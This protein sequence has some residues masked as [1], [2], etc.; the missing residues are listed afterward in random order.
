[1]PFFAHGR[2]PAGRWRLAP[3]ARDRRGVTTIEFGLIAAALF[4]LILVAME[5]ARFWFTYESLR[6]YTAELSRVASVCDST[7][8]RASLRTTSG[9]CSVATLRTEALRRVTGLEPGRLTQTV[10][11]TPLA[12]NRVRITVTT[13]YGFVF[14]VPF[15]PDTTITDQTVVEL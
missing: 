9:P 1:M 3:L 8:L 7:L 6:S 13:S 2:T 10:T 12:N 4:A 15:A 5:A 11:V 14:V